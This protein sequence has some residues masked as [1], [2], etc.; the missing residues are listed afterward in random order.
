MNKKWMTYSAFL[1]GV[2]LIGM[3]IGRSTIPGEWFAALAKPPLNPP[4]YLFGIVWPILYIMIALAGARAW[5]AGDSSAIKLWFVQMGLNFIWSPVFFGAQLIFWAIP[6]I[7]LV[8]AVTLLFIKNQ[9]HQDRM[10]AWLMVPYAAW[11]AFASY[12]NM[13]IFALN[14]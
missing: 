10:T 12:L 5:L 6:I 2:L 11:V 8:L 13:A 4:N 3:L 7:L 9:W 14:S 1:I